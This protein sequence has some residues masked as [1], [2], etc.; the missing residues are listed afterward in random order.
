MKNRGTEK[1]HCKTEFAKQLFWV[2]VI[3]HI[4]LLISTSDILTPSSSSMN[5]LLYNCI[6]RI[7]FA[8]GSCLMTEAVIAFFFDFCFFCFLFGC[9]R[10]NKLLLSRSN[11]F[12]LSGIWLKSYQSASIVS[13]LII[14][15]LR[16]EIFLYHSSSSSYF[17]LS[18]ISFISSSVSFSSS[19]SL[20]IWS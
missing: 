20:T 5:L 19:N 9:S 16:S 15:F 18:S 14:W 1:R 4:N 3:P 2:F 10:A 6:L 13:I 8:E 17:F 11:S 7:Y 12:A